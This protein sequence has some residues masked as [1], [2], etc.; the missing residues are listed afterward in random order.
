[1]DGSQIGTGFRAVSEPLEEEF[2]G[3]EGR[4]EPPDQIEGGLSPR[5]QA[6]LFFYALPG[7][8][9]ATRGT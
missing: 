6:A 9:H 1:M 7:N 2:G 4:I 8:A 3:G 5:D